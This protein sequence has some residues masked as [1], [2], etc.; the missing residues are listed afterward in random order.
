MRLFK[1]MFQGC[2]IFTILARGIPY[3]Q[4]SR[5]PYEPTQTVKI[6]LL[7]TD[8]KSIAAKQGAEMAIRKA[9]EEGGLKGRPFQLVVRSMEGPW[10]TGSKEAVN[11]VFEEKVWALLGS[12]DGRNAH[13][14]EQAA[15]KAGVVFLSAWA[16]DP[17]LSQAFVPWF[18]NCMPNDMQQAAS[19]IEEIYN[20]RKLFKIAAVSDNGYDSK[21]A[22]EIFLKKTKLAGKIDPVQFFYENSSQDFNILLDKINQAD[23][24]CII[25]FGQPSASVRLIQQIRQS[26]MNQPVF[27]SLSLLDENKLSEQ[28]LQNYENAILVPSGDWS[29]SLSSAFRQEFQETYNKSP[30]MVAAYAFD[31]MNLLIEAIRNAGS[32]D[33]EKIQKS[34]AN[35]HYKGVT[36]TIQFDDRGNRSGT[37]DLMYIRNG[38]PVAVERKDVYNDSR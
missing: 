2:L 20:K 34:L 8:K 3:I 17:T 30:G 6:G 5:T 21:L 13:L 18:F 14:V 16:S 4:A 23:V 19:L 25:L 28:E 9:N 36:G 38:L 12:H 22:L 27:G 24:N 31:G 7:I 15:T 35:I 1:A 32:P 26:K 33:R 29:G 10:G 37:Y 11:L